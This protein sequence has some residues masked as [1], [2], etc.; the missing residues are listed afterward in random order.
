MLG[1]TCLLSLTSCSATMRRS[2]ARVSAH[3]RVI[4]ARQRMLVAHSGGSPQ[5]RATMLRPSHRQPRDYTGC[6]TPSQTRAGVLTTGARASPQSRAGRAPG[7]GTQLLPPP[8]FRQP[9]RVARAAACF[10]QASRQLLVAAWRGLS[11]IL[12]LGLLR[13]RHGCAPNAWRACTAAKNAP[14][15]PAE[16][17]GWGG[18]LDRAVGAFLSRELWRRPFSNPALT[19]LTPSSAQKI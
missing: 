2:P 1:H 4:S 12:A 11:R 13:V 8:R 7:C 19:Y 16:S 17:A 15:L 14:R 3:L 5:G 10:A 18:A 6:R 9:A